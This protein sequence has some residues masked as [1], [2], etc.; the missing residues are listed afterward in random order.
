MGNYGRLVNGEVVEVSRRVW[1]DE[2][3]DADFES[4]RRV[5]ETSVGIMPG[6]SF[7]I[8]TVFLGL[9]HGWGDGPPMWFESM[10]FQNPDDNWDGLGV[11][12]AMRRY[13][14]F[15]EASSGHDEMVA[16]VRAEFPLW[17]R[18]LLAAAR[19]W[20]ALTR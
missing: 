11:D 3:I 2:V 14:T 4:E 18:V 9:N 7:W 12:V 17:R 15:A 6:G 8:S 19:D 1:A 10:A 5:A 20:R 13:S 16:E